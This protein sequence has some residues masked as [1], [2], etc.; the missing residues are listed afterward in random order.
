MHDAG[1]EAQGEPSSRRDAPQRSG[2]AGPAGKR[3]V[4]R[5][6]RDERGGGMT[7]FGKRE[8]EEQAR[9]Q[10][11]QRQRTIQGL[12]CSSFWSRAEIDSASR[13]SLNFPTRTRKTAGAPEA[14]G[15]TYAE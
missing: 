13:R 5:R 6:Q 14:G 1:D 4:E 11:E 3:H 7:E 2:P 12:N 9:K 8:R 10:G 15:M